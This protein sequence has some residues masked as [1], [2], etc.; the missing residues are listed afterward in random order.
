MN[1]K[2][3][4]ELENFSNDFNAKLKAAFDS[5]EKVHCYY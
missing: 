1:T 2:R 4:T 5:Y 3:V